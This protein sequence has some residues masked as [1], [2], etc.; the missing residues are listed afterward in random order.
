MSFESRSK[1]PCKYFQ[2][3][4]CKKGNSC[5][6][7]HVYTGGNNYSGSSSPQPGLEERYRS[8]VS[9]ASLSKLSKEIEDDIKSAKEF[10]M[11]PLSSS[12][13]L[14]SP[15]AVNLIQGRDLS[16]EESRYLC[17]EARLQNSLPAYETQVK[18]RDDDMSKCL[19]LVSRDP[20]KAARYLQL[21]TQKVKESGASQM[22]SYIE[23]PLDLTGQSYTQSTSNLFGAPSASFGA[24][25]PLGNPFGGAAAKPSPFGQP[26]FGQQTSQGSGVFGTTASA[27]GPPGTSTAGAFGQPKF[28]SSAFG[29]GNSA[30]SFGS[31]A[32]GG[33]G[34]SAFGAPSFGSTSGFSSAFGKPSF[35]SNTATQS[36]PFAAMNTAGAPNAM[37]SQAPS[38]QFGSGASAFGKPAFGSNPSASP[39]ASVQGAQGN[40]SPF[41]SVAGATG[42]Q[43]ASTNSAFGA[44]AFPNQNSTTIAGSSNSFGSAAQNL[45]TT[46]SFNSTKPF[47]APSPFGSS[48]A[49]GANPS[50]FGS[51]G[52]QSQQQPNTGFGTPQ[53]TAVA[54]QNQG[55]FSS[56]SNGSNNTASTFVQ[57]LSTG[58]ELKESDL[59]IEIIEYFKSD[60]FTL[61]KVPDNPP[62]AG[63]VS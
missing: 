56:Q 35:G 27:P 16:P 63:L 34:P 37:G 45:S 21:A 2:Q 55:A 41:G 54:S 53:G 52:F 8:F 5:N 18:A 48:P 20:R 10:S 29:S 7:A 3:G 59:P 17:Y 1:V 42:S 24:S 44:A 11:K 32:S 28:G 12:Y 62:P 57:G 60:R 61:Q 46:T 30:S 6:F 43:P 58:K 47:G 40:K 25:A 15:C 4:R 33:N 31:M 23:H 51:A 49:F 38:T 39:F 19:D 14:G 22:K 26:A 9:A 36:S 50:A 13:S